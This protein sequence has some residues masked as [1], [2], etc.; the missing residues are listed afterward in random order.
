MDLT[1]LWW[2]LLGLIFLV[3]PF[4]VA[5]LG[6]VVLPAGVIALARG[7]R[8]WS[9]PAK[10][11]WLLAV[12]VLTTAISVAVSG[13]VIYTNQDYQ[14][15]PSLLL[16]AA[17]NASSIGSWINRLGTL[18]L[19][20]L[21][22]PEIL[23]WVLGERRLSPAARQLWLAAGAYFACSV[24]LSGFVGEARNWRLN[25]LYMPLM[26]TALALCGHDNPRVPLQTLRWA[27]WCVMVGSLMAAVVAPTL[28]LDRDYA[29]LVP[30]VHWRLLG[31]SDHA[32]S[33]GVLAVLAL[34][35]ETYPRLQ[36]RAHWVMWLPALL[37]LVL[38]QSKTAW[39]E[40]AIMLPLVRLGSLRGWLFGKDP[41]RGTAG[42][43]ALLCLTAALLM[44]AVGIIASSD[45]ALAWIDQASLT[46]LTG[47][48]HIWE[49]TWSEFERSPWFGYGPSLWDPQ[50]RYEKGL[51]SVGQGH[52]QYVHT[53]GQAGLVGAFGLLVYLGVMVRNAILAW[54]AGWE[55]PLVVVLILLVRG[56]TETPLSMD[57]VVGTD[58]FLHILAFALC[59]GGVLPR[60]TASPH[61]P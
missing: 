35:L 42:M 13:R 11:A 14:A 22:V 10:L 34:M 48:T 4:M 21:C 51:I 9:D 26:L 43:L 30:G 61:T 58:A 31:L 5:A 52:N 29:S 36:P 38:S 57:S 54:R 15:N 24:L 3:T 41:A 49:I 6:G 33:L 39:V 46:T 1:E 18:L 12:V 7:G 16:T 55:L 8:R 25:T 59:A 19:A 56:V 50:Y 27:L 60:P 53:L 32:N 2:S 20:L 28:A 23:R 37:V 47:R 45:R 17:D 44:C 40:A